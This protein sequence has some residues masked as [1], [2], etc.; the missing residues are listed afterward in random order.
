MAARKRKRPAKGKGPKR[1]RKAATGRPKASKGT[2][3]AS[4]SKK[5]ASTSTKGKSKASTKK[6]ATRR[7]PAGFVPITRGILAPATIAA[8]AAAKAAEEKAAAEQERLDARPMAKSRRGL[9]DQA[10]KGKKGAL[11]ELDRKYPKDAKAER[12]R[13]RANAKFERMLREEA[14]HRKRSAASKRGWKKRHLR[15]LRNDLAPNRGAHRR[16]GVSETNRLANKDVLVGMMRTNHPN[17][18]AYLK[19]GLELGNSHKDITNDWIS[20]V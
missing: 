20:P 12:K 7:P 4:T 17:W 15:A 2:S 18:K 13:R 14:A 3:K 5:P 8:K 10:R 11:A 1:S 16:P 9:I 19:K 6:P